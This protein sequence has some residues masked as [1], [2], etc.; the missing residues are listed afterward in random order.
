LTLNFSASVLNTPPSSSRI[1]R[2]MT[3][4]RVVVLPVKVMRLTKYCLPSF[5][6]MVTSTVGAAASSPSVA[7]TSCSA[8]GTCAAS[9]ASADSASS[10]IFRSGKPVNSM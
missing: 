1:S 9:D 10:L 6:R 3:L 4:S 7:G 2:R 5:S 8:S